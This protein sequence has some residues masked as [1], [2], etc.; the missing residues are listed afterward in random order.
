[1]P[2]KVKEPIKQED[3]LVLKGQI[4]FTYFHFA[5]SRDLTEA[6]VKSKSISIAYKTV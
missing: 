1:M 5:A 6:M 4:L 3:D 2:M